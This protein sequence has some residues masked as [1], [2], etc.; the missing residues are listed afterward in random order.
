MLKYTKWAN[1]ND[2][3]YF[4][5]CLLHLIAVLIKSLKHTLLVFFFF[6]FLI[7]GMLSNISVHTGGRKWGGQGSKD[8][9]GSR[10]EIVQ[11]AAWSAEIAALFT[12]WGAETAEQAR[13][14]ETN[15]SCMQVRH[16]SFHKF[17][18]CYSPVLPLKMILPFVKLMHIKSKYMVL[19]S[20]SLNFLL[21]FINDVGEILV[22]L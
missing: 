2:I 22:I 4:S 12:L 8:L 7:T 14:A 9:C 15:C 6:K 18:L 13:G 11:W 1:F 5:K 16:F 21:I 17:A 19:N 10:L 3:Y 20:P